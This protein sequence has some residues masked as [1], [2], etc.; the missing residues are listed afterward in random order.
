MCYVNYKNDKKN[1]LHIEYHENGQKK[2]EEYFTDNKQEGTVKKYNRKGQFIAKI[3]PSNGKNT[4]SDKPSRKHI[5]LLVF[6][7]LYLVVSYFQ[8]KKEHK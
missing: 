7:V 5:A 1:G 2:L 8:H 4:K 6:C 3:K